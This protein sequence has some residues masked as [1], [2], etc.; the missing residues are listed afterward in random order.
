M[1]TYDFVIVGAGSAGCALANR[2]SESGRFSVLLLEAGKSSHPYSPVP[3]G[4]AKLLDNPAAN[5]CYESE[6]EESMAGRALPIPRG[7][8]LGGSSAINGLVF[9]R[10]QALDYDTWAQLGNRGWSFDDVLPVFRRMEHYEQGADELRAHGG[11]LRVREVPDQNPL[12]D[13]LFAAGEEVGLPR[14]RDYNGADQ[15]GMCKTQ[16]TIS[17]GRRMST[18]HCYLR[19]ARARKN[20]RVISE[21]ATQTLVLEGKRCVGVSYRRRGDVS[22]VRAA[23]EV[24]LCAGAINSPQLLELSGIG[25]PGLLSEH[26]IDVVHPLPGVGENLRDHLSPRLGWTLTSADAS[27]NARARGVGLLWQMLRYATTRDGFLSLPSAPMLAFV[28]T[29]EGL[30]TPDVQLHFMPYTYNSKQQ[31]HELPGMTAVIYQMRP[32]SVGSIHI[33]SSSAQQAPAVNFNFLANELDRRTTID[34]VQWTRKIVNASAMES[35][36]GRE[37][38]PGPDVQTDDEI[39]DWVRRTAET[40]YH[41]VGTCKM[42]SD[43]RAVVDERLRVH[44]LAGLRVADGSIMPTLVSGNTNGACIMIGERCSDFVLEAHAA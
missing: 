29:R 36:R 14:N 37:F 9:V 42:G 20:L 13:A 24:I 27:Y 3:M 32:E 22:Q 6:P 44:G 43:P 19:P 25:E 23:R 7:K 2:L 4:F 1:D 35:I 21:A 26:G 10:G 31:L 8:L 30:A 5:W 34:S 17:N 18:A 15:E 41:P 28:K 39:L 12:Y 33:R 11:P 38:K 40:A 16:T